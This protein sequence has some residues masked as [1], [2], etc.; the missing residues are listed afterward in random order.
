MKK[1]SVLAG[2]GG[3]AFAI[4]PMVA[5]AITNPPGGNYSASDIAD[6]VTKGHRTSVFVSMYVVLLSAVGLALLLARLREAVEGARRP[7]FWGLAVGAVTGWVVGYALVIAVPAA[8]AFGGASHVVL[9]SPT[10]FTFAE[11]GWA[12]MFGAGGLLL[13]CALIVF[14]AGPVTEPGWV[15]WSTLV[16]GIAALGGL[17]WFPFFVVYAWSL[18]LGLRL[19]VTAARGR[20]PEAHAQL[21]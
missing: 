19:V 6:F 21:A 15:R 10:I 5:F 4:L 1:S 2:V 20:V 16:A 9:T 18:I 7:L 3:L 17:A 13:G 8:M 14:A 11:A 12:I